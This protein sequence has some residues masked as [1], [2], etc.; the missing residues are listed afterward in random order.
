[1]RAD[2]HPDGEHALVVVGFDAVGVEVFAEEQLAAEGALG[3]FSDDDFLA[4][5][6]LP[7]PPGADGQEVALDGHL[8]GA[9]VDAR[10]VEVDDQL[11]AVAVGVHG[12]GRNC[13]LSGAMPAEPIELRVGLESHQLGASVVV[14]SLGWLMVSRKAAKRPAGAGSETS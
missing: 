4:V 9:G 12:Y 3:S 2:S 7:S 13:A 6:V 11:I 10:Q 1:M 14:D 8:E 5:V